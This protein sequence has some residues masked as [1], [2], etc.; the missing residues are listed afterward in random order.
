MDKINVLVIYEEISLYP[1]PRI[2][3]VQPESAGKNDEIDSD[4]QIFPVPK[5]STLLV[6][7]NFVSVH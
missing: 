6:L 4:I 3:V 5:R 7:D 1:R 2:A